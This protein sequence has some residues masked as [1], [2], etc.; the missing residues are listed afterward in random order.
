MNSACQALLGDDAGG[1]LVLRIGASQEVLHIEALQPGMGHEVLLQGLEGGAAQG[2]V[3]VP[4]DGVFGGLVAHDE[5]VIGAAA[6]VL[7]GRDGKTAAFGHQAFA[8]R[9]GLL[10]EHRRRRIPGNAVDPA[11]AE[12]GEFGTDQIVGRGVHGLQAP[13]G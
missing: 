4:P 2:L 3:V 9:H 6:G 10:I 12:A 5:L 13:A 11:Q 1:Q 7:A 8:A